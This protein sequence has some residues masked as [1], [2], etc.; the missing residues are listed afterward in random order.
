MPANPA[1]LMALP[2]KNDPMLSYLTTAFQDHVRVRERFGYKVDDRMWAF[3]QQLGV[4][5]ADGQP[6]AHFGDPRWVYLQYRRAQRDTRAGRRDPRRGRR[7][8]SR[9]CAGAACSSRP[10]MARSR[11]TWIPALDRQVRRALRRRQGLHPRRASRELSGDARLR[12]AGR[13]A[14]P[15]SRRLHPAPA[16]RRDAER[17][18]ARAR[19]RRF[20]TRSAAAYDVQIVVSDGLNALAL[21]DDGHLAPYLD[22]AAPRLC[23]PAGLRPA[24]EHV[25]VTNGRVRA[26]YRI[27]EMLF[28]GARAGGRRR[29]SVHVIGERPGNGHHTFSAYVTRLPARM[30]ATPGVVDHN[31]TQSHQQ[32]RRHRAGPRPGGAADRRAPLKGQPKGQPSGWPWS[33]RVAVEASLKAG[34]SLSDV[35]WTV[36]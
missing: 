4:I 32:H 31:H 35:D 27:G 15:R 7:A 9:A 26:G 33:G 3:F 2:T 16:D 12:R 29:R 13:H 34:P 11:R 1:Y 20:A 21:T 22:G 19:R 17:R 18:V 8:R 25:V 5:D 23:S 14:Q 30:W 24:P 10:A 6:T 36:L 28:G